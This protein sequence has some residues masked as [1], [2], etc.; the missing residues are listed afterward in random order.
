MS[1]HSNVIEVDFATRTPRHSKLAGELV[2]GSVVTS[3]E[4]YRVTRERLIKGL[5]EVLLSIDKLLFGEADPREIQE[6][7]LRLQKEERSYRELMRDAD[8]TLAESRASH[9]YA[10]EPPPGP[11]ENSAI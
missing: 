1:E 2:T 11:S 8:I 4:E 7:L 5:S 3:L 6:K 10:S 9:G